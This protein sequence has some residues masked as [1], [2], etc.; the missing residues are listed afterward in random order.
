MAMIVIILRIRFPALPFQIVRGCAMP[1]GSVLAPTC[2][3]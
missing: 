1:D 3:V 2:D